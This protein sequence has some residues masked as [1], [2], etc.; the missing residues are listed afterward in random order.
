MSVSFDRI[1]HCLCLV[2]CVTLFFSH[3]PHDAGK[4]SLFRRF[5]NNTFID[6]SNMS[7]YESRASSMGLDHFSRRIDCNGKA[8][9]IQLWY[10]KWNKISDLMSQWNPSNAY[11][12]SLPLISYPYI[13]TCTYM[14]TGTRVDWNELPA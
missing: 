10:R 2:R 7:A 11:H 12:F 6:T 9:R 8:I 4:T 14:D 3:S 5:M 13:H 1:R